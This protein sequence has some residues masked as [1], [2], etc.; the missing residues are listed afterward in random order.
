MPVACNRLNRWPRH[1]HRGQVSKPNTLDR[2]GREGCPQMDRYQ[3]L[4]INLGLLAHVASSLETMHQVPSVLDASVTRRPNHRICKIGNSCRRLF[5]GINSQAIELTTGCTGGQ[6][7]EGN[8]FAAA[9]QRIG[10]NVALACQSKPWAYVSHRVRIRS[11]RLTPSNYSVRRKI[12]F[13]TRLATGPAH[14]LQ[15][16]KRAD[17]CNRVTSP[18]RLGHANGYRRQAR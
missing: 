5:A 13:S 8:K 15:T 11:A 18:R 16:A 10:T 1:R 7:H 3:N 6:N 4:H 17:P 2:R 14:P 9:I 12:L